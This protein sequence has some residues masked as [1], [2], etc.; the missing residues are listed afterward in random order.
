MR[1]DVFMNATFMKGFFNH[2]RVSLC[3]GVLSQPQVNG[4]N[5]ILASFANH[6]CSDD[7]R[8][9]AYVLATA[10]HETAGR[11]QPVRE[12]L[13]SSDD[14]AIA[15]LERAFQAGKLPQVSTPYWRPDAQG[16]SWFGR[17]FVQLTFQRNYQAMGE[18]LGLDLCGNP[19]LAMELSASADILVV[20]MRDGLFSGRKLGDYFNDKDADWVNARRIVNGLDRADVVAGHAK[21]IWAGLPA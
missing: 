11:L 10:F 7:K 6:V 16:R 13:A 15:R 19:A 18:A 12:T 2:I 3:G 9:L 20:G 14:Q 1:S 8:C 21:V 5:A 17:G 4:L